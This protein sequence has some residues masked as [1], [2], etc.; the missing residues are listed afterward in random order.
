M[1]LW[2][3]ALIGLLVVAL[4]CDGGT[5]SDHTSNDH[6][7]S[8][9]DQ[10]PKPAEDIGQV[11]AIVNGAEVGSNAFEQAASRKMPAEGDAL[12]ADEKK[13]VLDRLIDE[14]LLYQEA[15]RQGLDRDPKVKKVMVNTLLRQEVYG[16]IRN[17]DFTDEEL[18]AYYESHKD[19]FVVPEKVQIKRILIKAGE[20]R[21]E[22]E[23][24]AKAEELRGQLVSNPGAFKEVATQNSED[25]YRRRGGDVGFV[26]KSGKPGLDQSI[27]DKAFEMN[28][29]QISEV[30]QTSEGFN[31]IQVAN[32]RERVERTY[33]QMKGSVLRKVK[34]E[35][36]SEMYETYTESLRGA[37]SVEVKEDTLSGIEIKSARRAGPGPMQMPGMDGMDGMDDDEGIEDG[38]E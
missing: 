2:N 3:S 28:V 7:P 1:R 11:L 17:S 12:S 27:V 4:G 37:A 34:N 20:E 32:K 19:E 24:K 5:T 36:L 10:A 31:I 23:A 38:D 18:E 9:P 6:T 25:P 13:E 15:L 30:F 21:S 16:S 8:V 26:P 35:K 14:E 22:D 29:D 33:Q